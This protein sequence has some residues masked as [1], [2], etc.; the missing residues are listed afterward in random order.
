[1]VDSLD[2]TWWGGYRKVLETRFA[3]DEVVI[4]AL[5]MQRL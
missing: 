2:R 4:R 1:M 3:Q 5:A